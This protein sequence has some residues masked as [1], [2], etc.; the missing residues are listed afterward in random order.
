MKNFNDLPSDLETNRK[1]LKLFHPCLIVSD[2]QLAKMCKRGNYDW[3]C[4]EGYVK[5]YGHVFVCIDNA[6]DTNM[7]IGNKHTIKTFEKY[8]SGLIFKAWRIEIDAMF[9]KFFSDTEQ[10]SKKVQNLMIDAGYR[11]KTAEEWYKEYYKD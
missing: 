3:M 6:Y 7:L 2:E 5:Y 9:F 8:Q 4:I 10:L 11:T 1:I